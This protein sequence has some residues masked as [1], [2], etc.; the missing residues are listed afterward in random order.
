MVEQECYYVKS[1]GGVDGNTPST[2][3]PHMLLTTPVH[4]PTSALAHVLSS[5]ISN[6]QSVHM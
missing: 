3:L 4:K 2:S 5:S 6:V 1:V